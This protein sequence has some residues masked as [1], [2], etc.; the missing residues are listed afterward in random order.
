MPRIPPVNINMQPVPVNDGWVRD[1]GLCGHFDFGP[2][3]YEIREIQAGSHFYEHVLGF[4]PQHWSTFDLADQ[5]PYDERIGLYDACRVASDISNG[6][7]TLCDTTEYGSR[8]TAGPTL[9]LFYVLHL[10]SGQRRPGDFQ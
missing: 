4:R 7:I 5:V 9:E 1:T 10:Y 2:L 6:H 8:P 3:S